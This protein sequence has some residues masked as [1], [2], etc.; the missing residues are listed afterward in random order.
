MSGTRRAHFKTT[1]TALK[2]GTYL[3]RLS[4]PRRALGA[5]AKSGPLA[6]IFCTAMTLSAEAKRLA[7]VVGN[8]AYE[9]VYPLKNAT[10]DAEDVADALERMDFEVTLLTDASEADFWTKLDE[11]AAN[12]EDA[13]S[14]VFFF[15]GHAFQ[16]GGAN[17]LVP[18]DANL[19]SVDAIK[20]Q[21]W[22]LDDIVKKLQD[23]N[24]QTLIFLDACRN[25]PL[26][27]STRDQAGPGLAKLETGTGTYVA[28]AT[29]PGNVTSD[30]AG[31]NSPFT[32]A[33]LDHMETPGISIS[34][35][36]IRVR[37]D[38][39]ADTF[40]KQVPF[41]QNSLFAQFYF[42]PEVERSAALTE[43]DYEMIAALDPDTRQRLLAALGN[44]GVEIEITIDD[45][46]EEPVVEVVSLDTSGIEASPLLIIDDVSPSE[47]VELR[48]ETPSTVNANQAAQI[49]NEAS[50]ASVAATSEAGAAVETQVARMNPQTGTTLTPG[51]AEQALTAEQ[52]EQAA[53]ANEQLASVLPADPTATTSTIR[54]G[55]A[56][57]LAALSPTRSLGPITEP[58]SRVIGQEV[59][60]ETAAAAGI[61]TTLDQLDGKELAKEAQRE[62]RRLGCYRM[63]IDG[64]WGKGSKLALVRYYAS[65]KTAPDNL[66]PTN[67]LLRVLKTE[68]KVVCARV[69]EKKKVAAKAVKGTY[70]STRGTAKKTTTKAAAKTTAKTSTKKKIITRTTTKKTASG[71][72]AKKKTIK[73]IN[74][75][76]F[77]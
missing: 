66:D 42:E 43:A 25:N 19:S 47:P 21:T 28:F 63:A 24:R 8:S 72:P 10:N 52:A 64:D 49:N 73:R 32:L 27:E 69:V 75:G 22:R 40:E 59:D 30:G 29:Q 20:S 56:L 55:D 68:E 50:R 44:S 33:L 71:Q 61:D 4:A 51:Q 62:L 45:A 74:S 35:M 2:G 1:Q 3:S 12:A 37:N 26:P 13:E 60:E 34:D 16:F 36:M 6:V 77:R 54:Q 14:T 23:R 46:P 76:V 57:V 58:R 18:K 41:E 5:L 53:A 7:L 15:S 48:V 67:A 17:Y 65:R 9:N 39:R 11:F 38:V 31:E 70:K